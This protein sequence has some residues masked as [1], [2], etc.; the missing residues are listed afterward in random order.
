M[1]LYEDVARFFGEESGAIAKR[2]A[3][4]SSN[5]VPLIKE[6]YEKIAKKVSITSTA[7]GDVSVKYFTKCG[8]EGTKGV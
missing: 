5:V 6:A 1:E 7:P 8:V 4:D 2:L 3:A